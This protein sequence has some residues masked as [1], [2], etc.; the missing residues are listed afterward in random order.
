M[1]EAH[2]GKRGDRLVLLGLLAVTIALYLLLCNIPL[3]GDAW[4]YGYRSA[5]WMADNG[6]QPIPAGPGR[7]QQAMGHPPLFFWLWAVLIAV[8]G[9]SLRVAHILPA[10]AT[11]FA[12]WGTYRLTL[13]L[14]RCRATAIAASAALLATPIF[15]ANSVNPL[16]D[17][18]VAAAATWTLLF[19]ARG[20]QAAAALTAALAVAL[21]EQAVLLP[22]VLVGVELLHGGWRRPG[23]LLLLAS[24]AA[25]LLLN[26]LAYLLVNGYFFFGT[27][28][29][30]PETVGPGVLLERFRSFFGFLFA[31]GWRWLP[32]TA[33]AALAAGG[34]RRSS[35]AFVLL[36]L[37]PAVLHP[38]G[39]LL[40][41]AV[42]IAAVSLWVLRWG[43]PARGPAATLAL[44][45]ATGLFFVLVVVISPSPLD[46]YRYL[47][48]AV[49]AVV[50]GS[51]SAVRR[52]GNRR[53]ALLLGG[54]FAAL[55]LGSN[56]SAA[57]AAQPESNLAWVLDQQALRDA[58]RYAAQ[59]GDTLLVSRLHLQKL[60]D[61][62]VGYVRRPVAGRDMRAPLDRNASYTAVIGHR[63]PHELA[64]ADSVRAGHSST[65]TMRMDT[66][67][68]RGGFSVEVY[69]IAPRGPEA[70]SPR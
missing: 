45:A 28:L 54:L 48:L 67:I 40:W 16:P 38:P 39:R 2:P 19:Y 11:F 18:A 9:N 3:Y 30:G 10:A 55:A 5:V 62:D 4:G 52:M 35:A 20:R 70:L 68:R 56:R 66:V 14:S 42:M 49:P 15:L 34:R 23:R 41:L 43:P 6:L 44:P 65:H 53:L 47:I 26:G 58:I 37:S 50:A 8:L 27:H 21:R 24:P 1:P 64:L 13:L 22:A 69:R 31:D 25:V 59:S 7:G 29:G 33:A 46:L 63:S 36:L 57:S 51:L 60:S 61:P 12:L 32:V 17:V